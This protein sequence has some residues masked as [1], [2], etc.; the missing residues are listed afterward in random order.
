MRQRFWLF[1]GDFYYPLGGMDD[2]VEDFHTLE[3][4]MVI[5]KQHDWAHVL[6]T[7]TMQIEAVI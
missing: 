7:Q 5:G 6:D 4:A 3:E 1:A 2:F